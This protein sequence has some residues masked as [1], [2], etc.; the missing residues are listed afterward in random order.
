MRF[1]APKADHSRVQ[2][3][4]PPPIES[5]GCR[6]FFGLNASLAHI[7]GHSVPTS[8]PGAGSD[9]RLLLVLTPEQGSLPYVL[10]KG[11]PG[12]FGRLS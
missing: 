7:T 4:P 2:M 6:G 3:P 9:F 5:L 8:V 12:Q 10:I 1:Y 11:L